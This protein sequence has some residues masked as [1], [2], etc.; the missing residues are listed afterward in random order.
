M[1][2]TIYTATLCLAVLFAA[3]PLFGCAPGS[4]A[5]STSGTAQQEAS[6]QSLIPSSAQPLPSDRP[7]PAEP[8]GSTQ[9]SSVQASGDESSDAIDV[10]SQDTTA[11]A[12]PMGTEASAE[13]TREQSEP[14]EAA[15]LAQTKTVVCMGDS[16]TQ[17]HV[18][19][20]DDPEPWPTYLQ[21]HLYSLEQDW[22]LVNLG[23]SG[24]MLLDE[25][26]CP[27]RATGNVEVAKSLSPDMVILMLGT[28]D[29]Y[30]A[31]WNAEAYRTEL[32]AL[33]NELKESRP[34]IQ[35][36]L[37]APPHVFCDPDPNAA[38]PFYMNDAI[39]GQEIRPIVAEI[40]QETEA[41]FVD[42]YQLTEGRLGWFPDTVHPN[43]AGNRAIAEYIFQSVFA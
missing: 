7:A 8:A 2:C 19:G 36:V 23:V 30:D 33:V 42:L 25:G 12:D 43:G 35:M 16:I 10:P 40:A 38:G 29:T 39:L 27:Y 13:E 37:M 11:P 28:N 21:E 41:Q 14:V 24:T 15:E 5:A 31:A 9:P 4:Q 1:R 17:G 26:R 20:Y 22:T 34:G 18:F 6:S 32:R 3:W